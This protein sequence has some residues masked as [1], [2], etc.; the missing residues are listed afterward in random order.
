MLNKPQRIPVR[1]SVEFR[2]KEANIDL[3]RTTIREKAYTALLTRQ[4]I[5]LDRKRIINDQIN[6]LRALASETTFEVS[7]NPDTENESGY[8]SLLDRDQKKIVKQMIMELLK[9]F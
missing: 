1:K 3:I 6:V 7:K 4:R 8:F 2:E 9:K 5:E